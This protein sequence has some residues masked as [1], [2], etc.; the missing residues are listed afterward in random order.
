MR[1][2]E[3]GQGR[4]SIRDTVG[5]TGHPDGEKPGSERMLAEDERR[6][7]CCATLLR[8]RVCEQR[9]LSGKAVYV[10]CLLS[11]HGVV[12]SADVC[13]SDIVTLDH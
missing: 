7:S 10:V 12:V 2:E 4:S 13:L 5:R 6:Q 1:L 3:V 8:I 11:H 9:A